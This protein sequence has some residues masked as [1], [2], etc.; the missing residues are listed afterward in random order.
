MQIAESVV[1]VTGASRGLGREVTR[2]FAERGA[3]LI[4]TA[5][6]AEAL[7]ETATILRRLPG[8]DGRLPE[9]LAVPGDVG[10]AEHAE[11]LVW[12]GL[13]RFGR[14]DVLINNASTLGESPMPR[15]EVLDPRVFE[16]IVRVNVTAPLRLIQLVLPQ[17][18]ARGSGVIINVTSD[19]AVEAYPGWG[20]YG[21]SKAALEHLTR[22][23]A[24]EVAGTGVRAYI[25]DPGEMNTRM[26]RDAEPGVDLSH[27]PLPE[28][29]AP[30]F[31]R[32]VEDETAS[33]G[34]F[35]AQSMGAAARAADPVRVS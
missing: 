18:K 14:I 35:A 27:L 22:I 5:R 33:F 17:M 4:L 9:V 34:R 10:D 29:A 15:L 2:L 28:V 11:R 25:V 24:A 12:L 19:A 30:A 26:H 6:G 31:V 23:L 13:S 1:F 3:R 16:E 20:G 21:A 8:P 7:E 32:L